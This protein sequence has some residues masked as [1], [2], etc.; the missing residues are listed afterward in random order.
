MTRA[1]VSVVL[2]SACLVF[3][4]CGWLGAAFAAPSAQGLREVRV[5]FVVDGPWERNDEIV[6]LFRDEIRRVNENDFDVR[7]PE[8]AM[9]AGTHDG[10]SV[11]AALERL[12]S[13]RSIDLVVAM[14][15]IST[16]EAARWERP[17][18]KPVVAPFVLDSDTEGIPRTERGTSGVPNL[19]YIEGPQTIQ[20]DLNAFRSIV[21]FRKLGFLL[22]QSLRER[23]RALGVDLDSRFQAL[24]VDVQVVAVG[25]SAD[26]TLAAL[27]SDVDA[28]YLVPLIELAPGEFDRLIQGLIEKKLP[29]F[30]FLGREDVERG[31]LAGLTAESIFP[32]YARRAALDVQ[33]ILLGEPAANL[34][35]AISRN[36]ELSL[37]M[38]TVRAIGVHPSFEVL[39]EAVIVDPTPSAPV[40][41]I[42]LLDV[43]EEAVR[44]NRDLLAKDLEV[45]A[46]EN[47]IGTARARLLPQL[48]AS[49]TGLLIDEDRAA[50]S[51]GSQAER[52]L[53]ASARLTQVIWSEEAWAGLGIEKELQRSREAEL[54]A[55]RLDIALDAGTA[56]LQYLRSRTQERVRQ[57]DLRLTRSNLELARIRRSLGI[58]GP[59]EVFRWESL[60]AQGKKASIA[61]NS[62]R[63][64]AEMEVNRILH[65]PLEE[66]F[67]GRDAVLE[68]PGI[69]SMERIG[70]YISDP[71]SFRLLREY[72]AEAALENSPELQ[73][74]DAI[75]A[76]KERQRSSLTRKYYSPTLALR[77]E[78]ARELDASGAGT[79][80]GLE[81]PGLALP[82]A[83]DTDWSVALSLSLPLFEGGSRPAEISQA[84]LEIEQLRTQRE[85][86]AER[87]EQRMRSAVHRAG[88]SYAAIAL[89]EES[90]DAAKQN[91]E[92]VSDAY[93][94]GAVQIIDLIDA[95]NAALTADQA[96]ADAVHDFLLDLIEVER[97]V[98]GFMFLA[99]PERQ[100][101]WY[102]ELDAYFETKRAEAR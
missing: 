35:V 52:T 54:D 29:S 84:S 24:G 65:R 11:Q 85:S 8:T 38:A 34:P 40:R 74:I 31:I 23:L 16:L 45:R 75:L 7:F 46:A 61:A 79:G 63:N 44:V 101:Q 2:V 13:D 48:D 58:S 5:G 49:L 18:T 98:G 90:A 3:L 87:I 42:G 22:N 37:N 66:S 81:I 77:G 76:A 64:L 88:A 80:G 89:S 82:E 26:E 4:T 57:D 95:Q 14:G 9:L 83:D 100:L 91:L 21:D 39:T 96:A 97:A 51:L 68:E 102:A 53:S 59:S 25:S 69:P 60:L 12:F 86:V 50:A 20:E 15:P 10:P 41:E 6:S 92:L 62:T 1:F 28:I 43:F 33:R 93:A 99:P 17:L 72:M 71:W 94:R 73:R 67:Q 56:Y 78:V 47:R 32:R 55:E 30:S 27:D 19:V 70:S 36:E